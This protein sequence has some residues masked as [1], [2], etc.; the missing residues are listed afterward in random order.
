[1]VGLVQLSC[2]V[3]S[4]PLFITI[5]QII[6]CQAIYRNREATGSTRL[7]T[8]TPQRILASLLLFSQTYSILYRN[9]HSIWGGCQAGA[10]WG[11]GPS[12]SASTLRSTGVSNSLVCYCY[13]YPY[14]GKSQDDLHTIIWY[15]SA[16]TNDKPVSLDSSRLSWPKAGNP[17]L[18][19]RDASIVLPWDQLLMPDQPGTQCGVL[20]EQ[21]CVVDQAEKV[22]DSF[23]VPFHVS[24]STILYYTSLPLL[25]DFEHWSGKLANS[26]TGDVL[27]IL[28]KRLWYTRPCVIVWT[29]TKKKGESGLSALCELDIGPWF[30]NHWI[31]LLDVCMPRNL[32]AWRGISASLLVVW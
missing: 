25:R 29:R 22:C 3:Q 31:A 16:A 5:W 19:S 14:V 9:A 6:T 15:P 23:A 28:L 21:K 10:P 18:P 8:L 20:R 13:Y 26:S 27:T 2:F 12:F 32:S 4:N 24:M 17:R 30:V 7:G 11:G 1:M